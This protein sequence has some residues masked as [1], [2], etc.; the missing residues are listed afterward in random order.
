MSSRAL[1]ALLK[2]LVFVESTEISDP[3]AE[4]E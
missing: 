4:M 1:E 2:I 3:E